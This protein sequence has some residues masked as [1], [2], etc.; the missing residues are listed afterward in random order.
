MKKIYLAL[1][2]LIP[3]IGFSQQFIGKSKSQVKKELQH[4]IKKNDTLS[5]VLTE[6]DSSLVCSVNDKKISPADF[7]YGFD[8]AGKCQSEKVIVG[9][10]SCYKKFLQGVL[11][12]KKYGWKK[13]NENQYVSKYAAQMMIE[14]PT[15]NKSF[16]YIILRTEWNKELY[17]MMTGN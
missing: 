12:Q 15:D 17:D 2:L 5:I 10:D 13:I 8:K 6:N 7:I 11:T 14:L 9:C 16:Q 1:L 4:Q 3:A